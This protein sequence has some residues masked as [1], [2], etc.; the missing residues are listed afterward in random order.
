MNDSAA[1]PASARTESAGCVTLNIQLSDG[2]TEEIHFIL[3]DA[4]AMP[5]LLRAKAISETQMHSRADGD[6]EL[7]RF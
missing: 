7:T 1:T 2:R 4:D 3:V 6:D 5:A